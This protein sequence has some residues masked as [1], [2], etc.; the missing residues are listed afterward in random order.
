[1]KPIIGIQ[2]LFRLAK[3]MGVETHEI[4]QSNPRWL[5][6]VLV[7]VL[8]LELIYDSLHKH[9]VH[10]KLLHHRGHVVWRR[11][12]I[13]GTMTTTTTTTTSHPARISTRVFQR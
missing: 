13:V 10:L 4:P 6:L 8:V 9:L 12:W 5:V 2:R 11:R 1:M 3:D 7:L